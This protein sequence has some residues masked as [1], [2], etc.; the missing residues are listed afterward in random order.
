MK[1]YLSIFLLFSFSCL[2]QEFTEPTQVSYSVVAETPEAQVMI[3][4]EIKK[5]FEQN[6]TLEISNDV[7]WSK[8]IILAAPTV[9]SQI[10]P[11]G[12]V[13]SIAHASNYPTVIVASN[14]LGNEDPKFQSHVKDVTPVLEYMLGEEGLFTYMNAAHLD[15]LSEHKLN[16]LLDS[17]MENF[18]SRLQ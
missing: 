3:E 14:V 5:R 11:K 8:L 6:A 7:Y 12:W 9:E 13:F 15:E 2:A 18:R 16:L 4:K 17:V 10:N 1:T